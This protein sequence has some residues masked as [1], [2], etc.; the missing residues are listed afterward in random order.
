M[1]LIE[2]GGGAPGPCI[3]VVGAGAAAGASTLATALAVVA[4]RAGWTSVAIDVDPWGGGLDVLFDAAADEGL[5][6]SQLAGGRGALPGAALLSRLPQHEDGAHVLSCD[7]P[8]SIPAE[9]LHEVIAACR[10]VADVVVLDLPRDLSGAASIA[11]GQATDLVVVTSPQQRVLLTADHLVGCAR[12]MEPGLP[13]SLVWRDTTVRLAKQL[14]RISDLPLLGV[15]AEDRRID[16]RQSMPEVP[17]CD[18]R[19]P[20]CEL[21]ASILRG[22]LVER[23]MAS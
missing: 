17:G 4:A 22:L 7:G 13:V 6:W 10:R 18:A 8:E 5:R 12:E 20:V 9:R 23:R 19:S 16:Q 2:P 15:L 1:D 3:A 11:L 14:A 21:A